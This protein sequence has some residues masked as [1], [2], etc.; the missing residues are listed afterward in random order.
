VARQPSRKVTNGG[1]AGSPAT[2]PGVMGKGL[3]SIPLGVVTVA[4]RNVDSQWS[5]SWLFPLA[6][7]RPALAL[8]QNPLT[9]FENR[10]GRPRKNHPMAEGKRS[11][12]GRCQVSHRLN[13]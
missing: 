5:W 7:Q 11:S 9:G 8:W 4:A 13:G 3:G 10:E 12:F 6:Q 1:C 2:I